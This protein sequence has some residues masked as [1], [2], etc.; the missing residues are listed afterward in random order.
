MATHLDSKVKCDIMISYNKM[1]LEFTCKLAGWL[2]SSLHRL[3]YE[4]KIIQTYIISDWLIT[5]NESTLLFCVFGIRNPYLLQILY[6]R[7]MYNMMRRLCYTEGESIQ[8]T[9][10]E[11]VPVCLRTGTCKYLQKLRYSG[12]Q[13]IRSVTKYLY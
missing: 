6:N 10:S 7:Y 3:H 11:Q 2:N 9:L 8:R 5:V 1:D 4:N 12:E 13:F